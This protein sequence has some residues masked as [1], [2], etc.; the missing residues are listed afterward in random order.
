MNISQ[1]LQVADVLMPIGIGIT[2]FAYNT[3]MKR[4][5]K[6]E[7]ISHRDD[8]SIE[9]R[10]EK[11]MNR[12]IENVVELHGKVERSQAECRRESKELLERL[13]KLEGRLEK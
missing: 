9:E 1:G 10:G 12:R 5:D 2:V 7:E 8:R 11:E 13:A 6:L 4:I 3:I